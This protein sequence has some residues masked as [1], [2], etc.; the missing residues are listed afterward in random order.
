MCIISN[1]VINFFMNIK[2][3]Y[4]WLIFLIIF[5]NLK[6]KFFIII[7]VIIKKNMWS[8]FLIIYISIK[9]SLSNMILS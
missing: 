1:L 7:N 4:M 3:I 2:I 6:K 8:M 9:N 5:V